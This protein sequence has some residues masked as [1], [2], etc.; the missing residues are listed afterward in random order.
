MKKILL[1][2]TTI[3]CFTACDTGT[4]GS[5]EASVAGFI[6]AMEKMD[7][8]AAKAFTNKNT[9]AVLDFMETKIK[10]QQEMGKDGDIA[11]IFGGLDFSKLD[12]NCTTQENKA[13]CTCCV[14]E[15]DVCNDLQL[16]QESGKWLIDIPKEN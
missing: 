1:F 2:L 14:K 6:A 11:S 15:S 3:I 10:I 5:P 4:S 16:V 12:Y 7:F 13:T 8:Q 9:D